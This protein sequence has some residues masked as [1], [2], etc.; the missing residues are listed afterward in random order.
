MSSML[1]LVLQ[2]RGHWWVDIEGRSLGPFDSQEVA[3]FAAIDA[4]GQDYHPGRTM[5]VYAEKPDRRFELVWSS[6]QA[7]PEAGGTK[8]A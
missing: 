2:S 5:Q 3:T 4:A 8:T 7:S 1:D 6:A